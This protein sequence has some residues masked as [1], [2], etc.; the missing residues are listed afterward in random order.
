MKPSPQ[1]GPLP[2]LWLGLFG[3]LA[4]ACF[5]QGLADDSARKPSSSIIAATESPESPQYRTKRID[6]IR[7]GD[8]VMARD[9]FG[10]DLGLKRVVEVYRRM[11]DHLRILEF[12]S[13]EKGDKESAGLNRLG[14]GNERVLQG[15]LSQLLWPRTVRRS[16]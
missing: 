7:V 5:W 15:K 2:L 1:L 3:I 12:E 4:G 16:W 8:I 6:E 9:E 13:R 10:N 14:I 11:S